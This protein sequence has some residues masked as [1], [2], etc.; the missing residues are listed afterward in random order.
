M[1]DW[2]GLKKIGPHAFTCGYCG[3]EVG[4]REGYHQRGQ[5]YNPPGG[6]PVIL[7]CPSCNRPSYF[8]S[9]R[10][11]SQTPAPLLGH[12]VDALPDNIAAIYQ[13]ARQCTQAEAYTA[14]VLACRKLLMHIGVDRGAGDNLRF[15]Q[16]VEYL[17]QNGYVPPN[18]RGWVDHIR[19]R[20]NEANHEIVIM[21]QDNALE[22]LSFVEM[23]LK[24]IYEFP[25]RLL[26]PALT[27]P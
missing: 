19:Q 15:I 25:A 7:I 6:S 24:F 1:A 12:D 21:S 17:A 27:N 20:G 18:G 26:P 8:E 13:E 5:D 3:K 2:E 4:S 14:C 23:L 16:Y 11:S 9:R 10:Y 22:L